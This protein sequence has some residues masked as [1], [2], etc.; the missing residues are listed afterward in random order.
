[1][2]LDLVLRPGENGLPPVQVVLT[3]VAA[4]QTA[5]GGDQPAELNGHVV[6]P[7]TARQ[8][9]DALTGAGLGN[10]VPTE[11]RRLAGEDAEP[12]ATEPVASEPAADVDE[13][14]ADRYEDDEPDPMPD[15]VWRASV[16]AR[17]D[18]GEIDQELD[19]ELAEAQDRWW[20]EY[21][22]GLHPDPDPDPDDD[23]LDRRPSRPS[24]DPPPANSWWPAADRAV[25]D[26]GQAMRHAQA[27][28]G[29]AERLVRTAVRADAA[30]EDTWRQSAAGRVDAARDTLGALTTAH[31]ADRR[32]LRDLLERTAGGGLAERPRLALVDALTGALVSLTDLPGLARAA[33]DGLA[34]GAPPPTD[35]Y[36]PGAA[37][38]RF[39]R[40][41]DRRCRFPGCRRRV[42]RGEIDHR[43]AWPQGPTDVTNLGGFCTG[44]HRGKH[45]APGFSYEMDPDGTFLVTTPSGITATTDPPPF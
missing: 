32:A 3:L 16:A 15:E 5:L 4:V 30:D 13:P 8:L 20:R 18:S 17:L 23:P 25:E 24:S 31:E 6:S 39:I 1:V 2:L 21:E 44:D 9:L 22:A 37:L 34:L 11:L 27:A 33:R 38:D 7:E 12:A 41:R 43:I 40:H 28:I 19:R 36:R 35:G 45:Q 10:G 29:H 14:A 26:A 42:C